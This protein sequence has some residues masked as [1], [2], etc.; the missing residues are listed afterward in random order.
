M[1][2]QDVKLYW[3]LKEYSTPQHAWVRSDQ[4]HFEVM[5]TINLTDHLW[6]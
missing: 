4:L 1:Q 6:R 5:H 3:Q 2:W